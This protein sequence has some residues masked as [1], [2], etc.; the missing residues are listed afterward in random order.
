[1][2]EALSQFLNATDFPPATFHLRRVRFKDTSVL[3]LFSDSLE[4]KVARIT[5]RFETHPHRRFVLV[6]DSGEKDPEV[7]GNI[8]REYPTRIVQILIRQVTDEPRQSPRYT[9]ALRDVPPTL[10]QLFRT[11]EEIQT[12]DL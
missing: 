6:G 9:E 4:T 11:R 5:E 1:M 8:A 12:F 10:W 2:Y 3:E 7:Y